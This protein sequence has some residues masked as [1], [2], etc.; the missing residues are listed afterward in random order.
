M[1]LDQILQRN[2]FFSES[3]FG[4]ARRFVHLDTSIVKP[5]PEFDLLARNDYVFGK[6]ASQQDV[7]KSRLQLSKRPLLKIET[8]S[9]FHLFQV[10][11]NHRK[12]KHRNFHKL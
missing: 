7:A 5:D 2:S 4:M 6:S 12:K 3:V 11:S 8:G 9:I 1:F 10:I